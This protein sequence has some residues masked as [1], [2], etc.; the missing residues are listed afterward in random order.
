MRSGVS[1]R[2]FHDGRVSVRCLVVSGASGYARV[3]R[4]REMSRASDE[5]K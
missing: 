5:K 4:E 3:V 1:N 2:M